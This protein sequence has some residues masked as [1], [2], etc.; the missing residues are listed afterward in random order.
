[1]FFAFSFFIWSLSCGEK[2]G[3]FGEAT[4]VACNVLGGDIIHTRNSID[5][6]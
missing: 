5:N 1:M 4:T 6:E 3:A 2:N